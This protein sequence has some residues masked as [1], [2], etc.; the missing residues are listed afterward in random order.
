MARMRY[1]QNLRFQ[2][3]GMRSSL[4]RKFSACLEY[5]LANSAVSACLECV[6]VEKVSFRNLKWSKSLVLLWLEY[7][8]V[9]IMKHLSQISLSCVIGHLMCHTRPQQATAMF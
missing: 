5:I 4:N 7:V 8:M 6:V 2:H 3:L 1:S 9:K